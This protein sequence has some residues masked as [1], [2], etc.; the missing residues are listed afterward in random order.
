[1]ANFGSP[2]S[3]LF[4]RSVFKTKPFQFAGVNFATSSSTSDVSEVFGARN[5]PKLA[6]EFARTDED[7]AKDLEDSV[8]LEAF[9]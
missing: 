2:I 8:N 9:S 7:V 4:L 5:S 1:M 3:R 6:K